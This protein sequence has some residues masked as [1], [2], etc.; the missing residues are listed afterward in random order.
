MGQS[1]IMRQRHSQTRIWLDSRLAAAGI[2][3]QVAAEFDNVESIKRAVGRGM[4]ITILP[5]YAVHGELELGSL[6][7]LAI[8]GSP[9]QRTLKL[10]WNRNIFFSPV[11][12]TFL[13]F[14]ELYL[15]RLAEMSI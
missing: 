15:P 14:L 5:L 3:V 13:R 2:E 7:A 4:G 1:F 8:Q 9:L 10:V 12:R 6:H 11:T